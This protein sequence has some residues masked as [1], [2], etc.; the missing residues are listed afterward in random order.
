MILGRIVVVALPMKGF[1]R[2]RAEN[3]C[4]RHS[5]LLLLLMIKSFLEHFS[6]FCVNELLMMKVKGKSAPR[7]KKEPGQSHGNTFGAGCRPVHMCTCIDN[8]E[9]NWLI[10]KTGQIFMTLYHLGI[11]LTKLYINFYARIS[12]Q[13]KKHEFEKAWQ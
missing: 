10:K 6:S 11:F 1:K 7:G 4:A 8:V 9:A 3:S 5:P 2:Q 13:M 12:F